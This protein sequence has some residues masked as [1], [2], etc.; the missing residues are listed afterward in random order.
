MRQLSWVG[1]G[2]LV[3][4]LAVRDGSGLERTS[5]SAPAVR[6]AAPSVSP[7]EPVGQIEV[8]GRTQCAP[9]RRA[10]IAP[11]PLHPVIEVKVVPGERVTKGQL[12]VKLDDDEARADVRLKRALLES[13]QY[14]TNEARRFLTKALSKRE[15]LPE[16]RLHE[17]ELA[18]RKA[19]AD[20]RAAKAALDSS[21][22]ELEHFSVG[23]GIEGVVS[24]LDVYPGFVSRPG[25]SVWGEIVDLRELDVRCELTPEQAD[26]LSL[27]QAAEVRAAEVH[28]AETVPRTSAAAQHPS[29]TAQR[30]QGARIVFIGPVADAKSGLVPVLVR[31][32]NPEQ[33]LRC[34][35]PV[36][37]RFTSAAAVCKK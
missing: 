9:G 19:E 23:A 35:V 30:L 26:E 8:V 15:I 27:G 28:T 5:G 29:S 6:S 17:A 20:Q 25:T 34:G 37:V 14:S 18:L 7:S 16:Q 24:W 2:V 10:S 4:S 36:S 13:A 11:V 33:R 1:F 31:L 12:L 21:E 22:A 32:P 3:V